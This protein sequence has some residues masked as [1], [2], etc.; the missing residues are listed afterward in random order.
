[1][2]TVRVLPSPNFT[3][4]AAFAAPKYAETPATVHLPGP[5]VAPLRGVVMPSVIAESVIPGEDAEPPPPWP[6]LSPLQPDRESARAAVTATMPSTPPGFF[7]MFMVHLA[8]LFV[9]VPPAHRP[10]PGG[11]L[12]RSA[13]KSPEPGR[14]RTGGPWSGRHRSG[15]SAAAPPGAR[16]PGRRAAGTA[17]RE[18]WRPG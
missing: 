11:A 2:F 18:G 6:P 16:S 8:S 1:M 17:P 4:P 13:G 7:L 10:E 5:A 12:E 3:P 15:G 9:H 14:R